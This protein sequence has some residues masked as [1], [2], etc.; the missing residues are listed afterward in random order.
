M[1]RLLT[2]PLSVPIAI[3]GALHRARA[4]VVDTAHF[5]QGIATR[6]APRTHFLFSTLTRGKSL[7]M[8]LT[9]PGHIEDE[10]VRSGTWEPHVAESLCFFL[11]DGGTFVDVGANIGYHALWVARSLPAVHVIAFEPNPFVREDLDRNVAL[12]DATNVE[13]R[14]S[15]LGDHDGTVTFHAQTGRSYNRGASSILKNPNVGDRYDQISVKVR[16]LDGEIPPGL[17][18]DVIKIDTEGFEAAV[19]RGAQALIARCQPVLVF[20]FESRFMKDPK[21]E[22]RQIVALLPRYTLWTL[23]P[24]RPELSRFEP[25]AVESR[26]YRADLIALPEGRNPRD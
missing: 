7:Q 25:G 26:F 20:E 6:D 10:I 22:L 24:E 2:W 19:L 18:V 15:A 17:R 23:G 1:S 5:F 21:D 11:Q 14:S 3:G 16:T 4:V 12:N 9:R 13:I 8:L